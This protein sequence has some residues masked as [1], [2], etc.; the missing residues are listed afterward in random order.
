MMDKS[1]WK[2]CGRKNR[3]RDEHTANYYRKMFERQ[4]GTK[5]DYYWCSHCN[6]FHLTSI[7]WDEEKN[8]YSEMGAMAAI[9]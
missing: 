7:A 6:G 9:I 1:Y 3:Y 2:Q 5:L 4:R 8:T